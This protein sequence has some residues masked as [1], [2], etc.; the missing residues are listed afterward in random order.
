MI[1]HQPCFAVLLLITV[2]LNEC[3]RTTVVA[4]TWPRIKS[5]GKIYEKK[6]FFGDN[7]TTTTSTPATTP[8]IG[9]RN[10][11]SE[12]NSGASPL[13]DY[14]VRNGSVSKCNLHDSHY[15]DD[16]KWTNENNCIVG[17]FY[18]VKDVNESVYKKLCPSENGIFSVPGTCN[19][20]VECRNG[21]FTLN[22]CDQDEPHFDDGLGRCSEMKGNA[23]CSNDLGH[24]IEKLT[25]TDIL[26]HI[27]LFISRLATLPRSS[28]QGPADDHIG[29]E[30]QLVPAIQTLEQHPNLDTK[31]STSLNVNEQLENMCKSSSTSSASH[32]LHP[33]PILCAKYI[34]CGA[35]G[36]YFLKSCGP[37]TVFNSELSIC[38]WPSNVPHCSLSS[39]GSYIISNGQIAGNEL[40]RR[41]KRSASSI[42]ANDNVHFPLSHKSLMTRK[43]RASSTKEKCDG[44]TITPDPVH[45]NKYRICSNGYFISVS[46]GEG[47]LFNPLKKVCDFAD[48]VDCQSREQDF[49]TYG[50]E[51]GDAYQAPHP[52]SCNKF[53]E[54]EN[55]ILAIKTCPPGTLYGRDEARCEHA[56]R[57]TCRKPVSLEHD[58]DVNFF[59]SGAVADNA[60]SSQHHHHKRSLS[61]RSSRNSN[62]PDN[63][64]KLRLACEFNYIAPH[65]TICT[66]FVECENRRIFIKT[67]GPGTAYNPILGQCD[68]PH[69]IREPD[70]MDCTKYRVCK[71]SLYQTASCGNN[72]VFH[73]EERKCVSGTPYQ[74][75]ICRAT[76]PPTT[77][78]P[79]YPEYGPTPA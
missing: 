17:P 45:C 16:G 59:R 51:S 72:Q 21:L 53:V 79:D 75:S 48:D 68:W 32:G 65:P 20:Y 18:A 66:R 46:C 64:N 41:R 38:D 57:V 5:Y 60:N 19:L 62:A 15:P 49:G 29:E 70:S 25:L 40:V 8:K 61:L 27:I 13:G 24:E 54:C 47:T 22:Q 44:E 14:K 10:S 26:R 52:D 2:I 30:T 71:G 67:C 35:P 39:D 77:T 31:S 9:E 28:S 1:L 3:G 34:Q 6:S 78:E 76:T 36:T 33:H 58:L 55:G 74:A 69:N 63:D 73:P 43:K 12:I 23:L 37:G 56:F 7:T 50:C 11:L 4:R 42:V